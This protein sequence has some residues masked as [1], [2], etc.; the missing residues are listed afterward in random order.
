MSNQSSRLIQA[1]QNPAIYGHSVENLSLIE[2]HISWVILTGT[3]VYKIKKPVDFGFLD[4]STLTK[5]KYY[6]D[7]EL[8]LNRRF[9]PELYLQVVT[10][11]G[12]INLPQI[13]GTG[14]VLEY[15]VKMKEFSQR[16]LFSH[17]A[18]DRRLNAA[19]IDSIADA[20]VR[21]HAA[22]PQADTNQTEGSSE[23]IIKWS[24]E[25]F[26]HIETATPA[27]VL[28]D[29]FSALKA[30]WRKSTERLR[31]SMDERLAAGFVRECHG[32][33][34]LGNIA[35]IDGQVTPFD[36]I[37]FNDELC[38]IDTTSEIAFVAMDLQARGYARFAS[39]FINRY[40]QLSGDY[41]AL[42]LLRYYIVYRALVR[43]K[44]ETL[45]ATQASPRSHHHNNRFLSASLYLDLA[46]TWTSDARPALIIMHGLSGSGKSTVAMQ[47]AEALGAICIRSDLE[48]KR[49][50]NLKPVNQYGEKPNPLIYSTEATTATYQ[51][52][53]SL[54][55]L[56]ITAGHSAI[57]DA[58]FL[59]G[60]D[61]RQF[62]QLASQHQVEHLVI[63]CEADEKTLR[64]RIQMRN[65]KAQDPSDAD[66][67]VLSHQL[68]IQEPLSA[69]EQMLS[70][71]LI[72]TETG[73]SRQQIHTIARQIN[74]PA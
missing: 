40:L 62:K 35:F 18:R 37:E 63:S 13:N 22:A 28:P 31:N 6:C 51:R 16:D 43:A 26:D 55:G 74:R 47:L 29:Y 56:I 72:C 12:D 3:Y 60:R 32:D 14:A 24:A 9:A 69:S 54:A 7:E 73:L 49:L 5:R 64:Q 42:T 58:T 25:N 66:Q 70:H 17:Y 67:A 61:R 38:W 44:V 33:L 30:W 65:N 59:A 52:L 27:H 8:R 45:A 36:C 19:H 11:S 50:H 4:F 23:V 68:R 10:I 53:L 46:K 41:A 39:R 15:A 1:L 57:V 2:T 34:H 71:T 21:F 20:M 48:R